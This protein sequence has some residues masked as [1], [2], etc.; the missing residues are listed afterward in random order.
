M[1]YTGRCLAYGCSQM[2]SNGTTRRPGA[3][4]RASARPICTH[5]G[6]GCSIWKMW[7][8]RRVPA[9]PHCGG[10]CSVYHRSGNNESSVS[11][12]AY[13][14][15]PNHAKDV[16][17]ARPLR[18]TSEHNTERHGPSERIG[19]SGHQATA[20]TRDTSRWFRELPKTRLQKHSH[21]TL[22]KRKE[23]ETVS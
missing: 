8:D 12:I 18:S 16:Q 14:T 11:W 5:R 10:E 20:R 19:G 17:D 7:R 4:A 1:K 13:R 23:D 22:C 15:P 9:Y 2:Y 3:C 6:L 21:W